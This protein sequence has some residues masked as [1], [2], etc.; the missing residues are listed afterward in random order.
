M[1]CFSLSPPS[2][3]QCVSGILHNYARLTGGF[4]YIFSSSSAK[5]YSLRNFLSVHMALLNY[6]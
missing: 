2:G 6:F 1:T 4:R 5:E 3:M